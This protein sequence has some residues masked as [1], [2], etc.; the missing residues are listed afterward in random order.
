MSTSTKNLKR[1]IKLGNLSSKKQKKNTLK[2][3][4][5]GPIYHIYPKSFHDK[6]GDGIGDIKGFVLSHLQ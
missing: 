4:Q 5:E 6:S 1:K 3:W 2:W